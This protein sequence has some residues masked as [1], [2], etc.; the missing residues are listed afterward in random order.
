MGFEISLSISSCWSPIRCVES[1]CCELPD[2]KHIT[3]EGHW[4]LLDRT[5]I[6]DH[7]TGEQLGH[8]NGG[9]ILNSAILIS[10]PEQLAMTM[11]KVSGVKRQCTRVLSRN[12]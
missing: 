7:V 1:Y 6:Q 12:I 8:V 11:D 2:G 4:M 3:S 5:C 10:S 9:G